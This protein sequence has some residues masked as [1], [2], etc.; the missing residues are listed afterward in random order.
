M[1]QKEGEKM[2]EIKS[3]DVKKI[4]AGDMIADTLRKYKYDTGALF[5]QEVS[6]DYT[7]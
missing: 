2:F 3:E 5:N 4:M 6:A 1:S 7:F